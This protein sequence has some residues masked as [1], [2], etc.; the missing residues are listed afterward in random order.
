MNKYLVTGG[1]GFIGSHLVER[2]VRDGHEVTVLDD[3]STGRYENIAHLEGKEL[4]V[5]EGDVTDAALVDKVVKGQHY[6]LHHA[7]LPSVARSVEDPL[8]ANRVNVGGTL[9]VLE[10]CRRNARTFRRMVYASSSAVYGDTPTLPKVESMQTQPM[11]PYAVSKL[12][13]EQYCRVYHLNYGLGT[14]SLRYFNVFGP[15]QDPGSDY[16]A[17]VPRFV[18][19]L[20]A[21]KRP[22]VFGD[23]KQTR[24][25]THVDNVVE[26]NLQALTAAKAPGEVLN[27]ACGD[28]VT[29]GGL[30]NMVGE[31]VGV[32]R[33]PRTKPARAGD[34]RHSLADVSRA[35]DV[36]GYRVQLGV[37]AGLERTV[38]WFRERAEVQ[39]PAQPRSAKGP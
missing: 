11:S 33:E 34:V 27:V 18:T 3:F 30:A 26:A 39:R 19:A 16:A 14:V 8:S 20:L 28:R 1:A 12:A 10:A 37:Q 7:A 17:V 29:I 25:F 5:V 13:G 31:F 35:S 9:N 32:Q 4:R 6:V 24:D 2:L 38:A 21:K 22:T 36:I 15:R 23:G